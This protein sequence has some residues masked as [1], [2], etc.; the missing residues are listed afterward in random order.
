M[1]FP[2]R[3]NLV[4]LRIKFVISDNLLFP[5]FQ[6]EKE[7]EIKTFK[8][9]SFSTL[10]LKDI[11]VNGNVF[12]KSKESGKFFFNKGDVDNTILHSIAWK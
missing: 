1:C 7:V 5:Q 4:K 12:S 11:F 9:S 2:N 8:N 6:R 10:L 3:R